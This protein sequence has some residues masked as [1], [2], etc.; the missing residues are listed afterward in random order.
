MRVILVACIFALGAAVLR[1][2][3]QEAEPSDGPSS[4]PAG[5]VDLSGAITLHA[6]VERVFPLFAP[7]EEAKWAEGW[8]PVIL[9]QG[10]NRE[11]TVFTTSGTHQAVWVLARWD[12]AAH[13]VHYES[14][15][16]G[17]HVSHIAIA[18]TAAGAQET[19]CTVFYSLTSLGGAGDDLIAQWS[20][21]RHRERLAS[22]ERA[23][24]HFLQTGRRLPHHE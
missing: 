4:R 7:V 5:H 11:G 20:Q 1:G 21:Q 17:V 16:P 19:R 23:I 9:Y 13:A 8:A 24:N 14:V 12:E 22:W 3:Q 2:G 10:K 15:V 18:C 6:P